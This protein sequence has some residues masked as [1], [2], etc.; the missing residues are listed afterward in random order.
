MNG[1]IKA[2]GAAG[3]TFFDHQI[4]LPQLLLQ[5]SGPAFRLVETD[6]AVGAVS[7]IGAVAVGVGVTEAE[8][9]LFHKKATFRLEK[10][11]QGNSNFSIIKN[12]MIL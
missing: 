6:A 11:F 3:Q 12:T 2:G 4:F 5:Q 9:V 7:G 8:N 10:I 1:I